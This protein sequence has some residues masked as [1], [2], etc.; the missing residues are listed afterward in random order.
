MSVISQNYRLLK[1]DFSRGNR[2]N[3]AG[4]R[5]G[6]WR[7]LRCRHVVL[8]YEI[9]DQN[10]PVCRS[11]VVKEKPAVGSP[12]FGSFPSDRIAKAAKDIYVCFFIHS[13]TYRDELIMENALTVK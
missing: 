4:A 7:M 8:C 9:L 12:F 5:S 2:S 3:S 11:I 6:L 1:A 13:L 10:R